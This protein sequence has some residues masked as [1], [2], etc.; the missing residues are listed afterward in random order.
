VG[1]ALLQIVQD[2]KP[3]D[4]GFSPV[5]YALLCKAIELELK[6]RHLVEAHLP[7][8]ARQPEVKEKFGHDI[9]KAYRELPDYQVLTAEEFEVLD[10]ASTIYKTNKGFDYI[11]VFDMATGYSRFPDLDALDAVARKLLKGEPR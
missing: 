2:F 11:A 10:K 7:G 4:G 6:S 3:P 1:A 5:P 9:S 8:G